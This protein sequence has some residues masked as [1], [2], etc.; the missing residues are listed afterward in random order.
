MMKL[1]LIVPIHKIEKEYLDKCINSIE[2]QTNKNFE[3]LF[4]LKKGL[5]LKTKHRIVYSEK[6]DY[7]NM[8]NTG[9][10]NTN[11]DYFMILEQDDFINN[12]AI[13]TI[14]D[15]VDYKQDYDVLM[16]IVKEVKNDE[17]TAFSNEMVWSVGSTEVLGEL[18]FEFA[19]KY[20]HNMCGTIYKT[21]SYLEMGGLKDNILLFFEHELVLRLLNKGAK[22]YTIP[23][24]FYSHVNDNI[25]SFDNNIKFDDFTKRVWK[26]IAFDEH[27]YLENR[28]IDL[29]KY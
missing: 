22:F 21:M 4:V 18:D 26:K 17:V 19:K 1:T 5:V 28:Q 15:Y 29:S 25:N 3:I 14:L 13:N 9:A 24:T 8:V 27:Y 12:N 2:A 10:A 7:C 11:T 23:K 20:V 16:S 6:D